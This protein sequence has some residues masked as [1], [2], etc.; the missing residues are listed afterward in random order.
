MQAVQQIPLI[1]QEFPALVQSVLDG[2]GQ[3][4]NEKNERYGNSALEPVRVFSK[5]DTRE[6]IFVRMDDKLS[7]IRA[8]HPDD[9]EDAVMDLL[10]YLVLL[11]VQE[12]MGSGH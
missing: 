11:K 2:V 6:Q 12:L 3:M 9:R 5:A 7:R 8:Q 4:L 1:K 10:G